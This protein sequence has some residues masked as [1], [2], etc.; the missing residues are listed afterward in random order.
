MTEPADKPPAVQFVL[1]PDSA[2]KRPEQLVNVLTRVLGQEFPDV[3]Q[4]IAVVHTRETGVVSLEK[5]D[6]LDDQSAKEIVHRAR[7]VHDEFVTS[8]WY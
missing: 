8:P 5:L 6:E 2:S 7:A 4:R 1:D 3:F